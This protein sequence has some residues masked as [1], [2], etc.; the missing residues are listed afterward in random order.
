MSL[1]C[2]RPLPPPFH[3]QMVPTPGMKTVEAW[4]FNQAEK[5]KEVMVPMDIGDNPGDDEFA[6]KTAQ[7]LWLGSLMNLSP[8]LISDNRILY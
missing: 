1:I 5:I 3:P 6:E 4:F 7:V 8:K 2:L